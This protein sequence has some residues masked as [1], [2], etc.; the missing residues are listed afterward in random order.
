MCNNLKEKAGKTSKTGSI[1]LTGI[2]FAAASVLGIFENALQL[3]FIVPGVKFGLSNIVVMFAL[4]Y[5]GTNKTIL[6]A[7]LKALFVFITR[8]TVAGI[9]SLCGGLLSVI[10]MLILMFVFKE[11]ISYLMIS[12]TGA[13]FHNLGQLAAISLLYT[14]ILFWFYLPVLLI[15]GII[16]GIITSILL[17]VSLTALSKLLEIKKIN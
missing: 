12:I 14:N 5:L 17:K 16:A 10:I 13:V 6:L 11:K 7:L 3:P 8:G 2:L 15:S 9:L 1:V 4:F